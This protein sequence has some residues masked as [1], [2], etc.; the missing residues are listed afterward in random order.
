MRVVAIG[1]SG[2]RS[3]G[4]RQRFFR[5]LLWEF[6]LRER[7]KWAVVSILPEQQVICQGAATRKEKSRTEPICSYYY[8]IMYPKGDGSAENR[9]YR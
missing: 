5:E 8:S 9:T 7:R 4:Q 3:A 1:A 6:P 2:G